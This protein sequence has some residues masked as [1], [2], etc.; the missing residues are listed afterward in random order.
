L[1]SA[2]QISAR[3]FFAPGCAVFGSADSTLPIL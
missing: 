2:F 1:S 3:A